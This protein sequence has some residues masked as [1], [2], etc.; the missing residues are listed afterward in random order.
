[1][2]TALSTIDA[3]LCQQLDDY[4]SLSTTTNITT[5]NYIYAT[6]LNEWDMARDNYFLPSWWVYLNTTANPS[7][8]RLIKAYTTSGA[9]L[10]I[11]GAAL[12][13]ESAAQTIEVT[14]Y[15]RTDRVRAINDALRELY[16]RASKSVDLRH[17]ITN[18]ILPD[19]HFEWW[20]STSA[21]KMYSTT[22]V[23]L[24]RT[25]TAGLTRGGKYSALATA[26][27]A[28][29][30]IE[31]D[32]N[33]YPRLLDLMNQT[34]DFKAWAYPSTADDA[35][36]T[37]IY[38]DASG[39]AT[40]TNSTTTCPA[41]VFTLLKIEDL[42]IPDDITR[43]VFQFRV[44]T[45]GQTAYFDNARVNGRAIYELLLPSEFQ[46]GALYQVYKQTSSYSDDPCDDLNPLFSEELWGW[47][48]ESDGAYKYLKLDASHGDNYLLKLIG[49]TPLES[50]SASTD[51]ISLDD[52]QV[53]LVVAYSKYKFFQRKVNAASGENVS[54]Y[55][56]DMADAY[57]E[58][59]RLAPS[60]SVSSPSSILR[61]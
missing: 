26:T 25:N 22:N 15:R 40:T 12:A 30:V 36:L 14:R 24:T 11:Y 35:F 57:L 23:T 8:D 16:P 21:L 29:G 32:S 46:T 34:I 10:E 28:D 59:L 3:R 5:N 43:I 4:I 7:V 48:T 2:S 58:Y 41:S 39:T 42:A 56:L 27:A 44:H 49:I 54:Q 19:G 17:L 55:R 31:L 33:S 52:P 13:A 6:G 20:T 47:I 60:L 61:I 50:V 1:M 38:Y 9:R 51:T 37:I 45:S 18:N 53:D